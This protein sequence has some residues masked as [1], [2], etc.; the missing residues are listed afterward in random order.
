M[1]KRIMRIPPIQKKVL[2]AICVLAVSLGFGVQNVSGRPV[3]AQQ[4]GSSEEGLFDDAERRAGPFAIGEQNYTVI[5]HEKRFTNVSDRTRTETLAGVEIDDAAG[6]VSYM[7]SFSYVIDQGH[8]QRILSAFAETISGKTGTGLL[9]HYRE[10]MAASSTSAPQITESWQ[11]FGFVNGKLAA[12]GKPVPIGATPGGGPS[13]GVMMRAANGKVSAISQPDTI[14][15]R[16]WAGYFYAFVPLRVDWNH[17]G[18]AQGQRCLDMIGG[19]LKEIGCDMRAEAERKPP[20]DE[21]TSVRLFIEANENMGEP[22]HVV[23]QKDSAI[24]ILGSR[25]MTTWNEN[26][27]LIQPVFADI[28]L[29]VRIDDHTGWIHG[30]EDFSAIGLLAGSPSP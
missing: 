13:M 25:A 22:E 23:M 12:L 17:G 14:E 6:R 21:S 24:E 20:S 19:R 7:N 16:T 9:I 10:H 5:F 29:H 18:L 2:F 4:P 15:V 26:G 8:F 28:W 11:F 3:D 1:R 30:E 27:Q